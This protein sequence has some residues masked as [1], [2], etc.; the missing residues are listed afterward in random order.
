[1]KEKIVLPNDNQSV[2]AFKKIYD[3]L[4]REFKE[5]LV[6]EYVQMKNSYLAEFENNYQQN[7][8][9][10]EDNLLN[11]QQLIKDKEQELVLRNEKKQE[12][13][14]FLFLLQRRKYNLFLKN[15]GFELWKFFAKKSL[16]RKRLH[17]YN[18]NWVYRR[19]MEKFFCGWRGVSHQWFKERILSEA[20]NFRKQKVREFNLEQYSKK[21]EA[22]LI[23]KA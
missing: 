16:Q 9:V 2:L 6:Q 12:R 11:T 21:T 14:Q 13:K 18:R 4:Y 3:R 20:E 23:Y 15:I 1:M 5:K 22:L 7:L 19:K 17:A 10:K 8:K